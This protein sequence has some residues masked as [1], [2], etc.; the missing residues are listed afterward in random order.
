[1]WFLLHSFAKASSNAPAP[2]AGSLTDTK[3]FRQVCDAT[4]DDFYI[5]GEIWHSS[6]RWLQGDEFHAVM[7]YAYTDAILGYFVKDEIG[8]EKMVSEINSQL[9]LYPDQT[10][11]MQFNVLDSHDT[12]RLL[13]ETKE[14]KDLMKQV[15]AFTYV[16]PGV[17]CLY[18]GDEIGMTG[19]NDPDCRKCM[20]WE[21]EK[22]DR[23]LHQ[24][25]K[26]L[27]A[28]RRNEAKTLS[29]G[30][31]HWLA[32]ETA[33]GTIIFERTLNNRTIRGIFNT[34][35]EAITTERVGE[36]VLSN[37][38]TSKNN[39]ITIEPKGFIITVKEQKRDGWYLTKRF[40][41]E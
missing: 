20:V 19:A 18:Y 21:E 37:G 14:D 41:F 12:A 16:Q 36:N 27:I 40:V 29:E 3:K 25:V 28:L 24:F 17:P 39:A 26:D 23:E 2:Q 1:M 22:Q 4:K 35:M 32:T 10:N 31:V 15:M 9:M 11:Q 13:T 8:M 34:G 5:L 7:N 38:V 6:Q 30:S 33:S